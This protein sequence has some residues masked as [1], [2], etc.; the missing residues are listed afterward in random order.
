MILIW[1]DDG[2][3]ESA[4][5]NYIELCE[6]G[7]K[8]NLCQPAPRPFPE[9]TL[10]VENRADPP[11]FFHAGNLFVVSSRLCKLLQRFQVNAEFLPLDTIVQKRSYTKG[12]FWLVNILD[13]VP[14]L[15]YENSK[16]DQ[17]DFDVRGIER[18][19]LKESAAFGHH[20][21]IVGPVSC[22][23]DHN[24][25]SVGDLIECAS[26]EIARAI[27]KAGMTGVVF[28]RPED[29][30]AYPARAVAWTP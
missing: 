5:T 2:F 7:F 10:E 1:R 22:A 15:D 16:Y 18:I 23:T 20:L 21:F 17:T 27:L 25:R 26:E 4:V 30:R 13:A 11:D 8:P 29:E 6:L 3:V 28:V 24:P 12:Q 19:V 14:C 9:S